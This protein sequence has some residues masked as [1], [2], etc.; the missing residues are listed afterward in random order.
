MTA[1]PRHAIEFVEVDEGP[2][3]ELTAAG[4]PA[5]LPPDPIVPT[6]QDPGWSLWGDTER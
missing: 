3:A 6:T 5:V 1:A 4:E 2:A